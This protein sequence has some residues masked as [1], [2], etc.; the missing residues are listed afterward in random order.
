LG[1]E[2]FVF[3]SLFFLFLPVVFWGGG[4]GR[5]IEN[6]MCVLILSTTVV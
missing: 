2:V 3:F 4:G 6:K 1:W 5:N